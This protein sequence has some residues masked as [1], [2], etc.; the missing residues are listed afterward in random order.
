M[1]TRLPRPLR[2]PLLAIVAAVLSLRVAT[3]VPDAAAQEVRE[4]ST[5]DPFIRYPSVSPDGGTVAFSFQGDL[6][7][8]PVDGGTATRITIHEAYEGASRW[9]PDGDRIAFQSDRYG[10]EDLFV[11]PSAGGT[12]ERLTH[13]SA[14]DELGGWTSD[15]RLLFSTVRS[16]VQAEWER[17]FH[18]MPADGGTPSRLVDATG[19]RPTMSPDGRFVAFTFGANDPDRK[20]YRGPADRDVWL[21]DTETGSFR[22]LTEFE[23]ND[24]RPAWAGPRALLYLSE[25]DGTYDLYRLRLTDDGRPAGEPEQL[26]RFDDD[27]PRRFDVSADGDVVALERATGIYLL[28]P[29]DGGDVTPLEVRIPRDERYASVERET[30]TDGADE[31]AVSPD[32]R[33]A[34]F[35]VRGEIF[36]TVADTAA[37]ART[38]TVRLTR[39]PWRDRDVAWADD[40]TLVFSSDRDGDYDLYALTSAD[41]T[42]SDLFFALS[43]QVTPLT[44]TDGAERTPVVAP[45]GGK[46]AFRRGRGTLVVADLEG[47]ELG[48]QDT[49][50]TGWAAPEDVAWSP[51]GRWLAYARDDLNF[52]T[53]VY[54]LSADGSRGP[55]NV[56]QHPRDDG[57]PVWSPDGSKL[58]FVSNRNNGDDDL[59]Y[60]W[61]TEEDWE[62]TREDWE[63]EKLRTT[64][65]PGDEDD[66]TSGSVE[67][68]AAGAAG[69]SVAI[70][71]EGI[72][73][74]LTQ[75]TALPGNESDP[76]IS[77]DGET[78]YFVTNRNSRQSW[79]A[80][81]DLWKVRWDGTGATRLTTGDRSPRA[82]TLA[83]AGE[84]LW[85]LLPGG[86]LARADA[87][88]D[89]AQIDPVSFSARMEI[90][91]PEERRQ[92]FDEAWRLLDRNF[93]DP[94]F[95]G[96][97]WRALRSKYEP[98]AM[99][100]STKRDFAHVFNL[101]LGELNASHLGLYTGDRADREPERTGRLGVEIEPVEDGVRVVRVV[102][103]TP[104]DR[105]GSRLHPGDVITA[106]D[107]SPVRPAEE[108]FHALLNGT[109]GER[110][111]LDVRSPDGTS[112]RVVIRPAA[113]ISDELYREW[114]D[115]RRELTEEYSDGRLGYIHV[116]GMNWPSFERF[117]RELEAA[118]SGK[119]G[120]LVDVRFN[121]GGWT[122]DM[123]MT[124]LTYRQHAYTVPRGATPDLEANHPRFR[125]HYPFGE[126]LPLSAWTKPAA[127]LANQ[128]SYSNAEIFSHAFKTLGLGPLVGEPT[129]GAVI[130][131]GGAGLLDGSFVRLPFRAWYVKATGEN[132]ELGPAVPDVIIRRSPDDRADGEDEQLR[133]A[134]ERLLDGIDAGGEP[135]GGS[136]S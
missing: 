82:L 56:T 125:E 6:F 1:T 84:K 28:R 62:R 81:Q 83:P 65:D 61:L 11:V 12:P 72:W 76:V 96:Q 130:S 71:L 106:V 58:G 124:V 112:R 104:A 79:E 25:R 118:G 133:A 105:E 111:A 102:P 120:L 94:G 85:M 60:A 49:L 46:I 66:E 29:D 107:G 117:E 110:V 40:T 108:S 121:G 27:G 74:R 21:H 135:D 18:T 69:D 77:R 64:A 75:V 30:F 91:H 129:F 116:E 47:R 43:H 35:V 113:S 32:G 26:T 98:W 31:Y 126:R 20:R 80:E 88:P 53:E 42:E 22:K 100:A 41:S 93:Y 36:L 5:E 119:E 92:V 136:G 8:V 13:H 34:A 127:A 101:M 59:W 45:S 14:D 37:D 2:S 90:R 103:R 134:V 15:G 17:E 122:T 23:G 109:V 99:K 68:G 89:R 33:Y 97:D 3:G 78:F 52:N 132:M 70:D 131:T 123:L 55:V 95:H 16:Y 7:T 86:R 44:G 39:H 48:R 87:G 54:L 24:V 73:Q 10:N 51:D 19:Y 4:P 63:M 38:R 115:R 114:V 50:L 128:N 67:E 9:S 57:S